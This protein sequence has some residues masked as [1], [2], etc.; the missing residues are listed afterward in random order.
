MGDK[1]RQVIFSREKVTFQKEVEAPFSGDTKI[2]SEDIEWDS[3]PMELNMEVTNIEPVPSEGDETSLSEL[4]F[5]ISHLER[6]SSDAGNRTTRDFWEHVDQEIGISKRDGEISLSGDKSA[7]SN[8]IA[9]VQFLVENNY[10]TEDDLPV[11]SGWKRNLV[12]TEPVHQ[13][14]DKMTQPEP[15]DDGIF[16]ETKYSR[17]D[18]QKHISELTKR[19]VE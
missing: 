13:Q 16:V 17:A 14:G 11:N 12:H 3:F 19:F 4:R 10:L 1:K 15:V 8:L 2:V 18:I 5:T 6:S 7:K 9:F